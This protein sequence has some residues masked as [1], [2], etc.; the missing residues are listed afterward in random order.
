MTNHIKSLSITHF[1][2]FYDMQTVDFA[3][4]NGQVASGMT[5]IVGP[6]NSGKTTIIEAIKKFC[7][8][9]PN[10]A[11]LIDKNERHEGQDLFL[12]IENNQNQ[13][14]SIKLN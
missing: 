5:I 11:V 4:P 14:K 3:I 9:N 7:K 6:N 1:R 13:T 12:Q 10:E 2:G 8:G